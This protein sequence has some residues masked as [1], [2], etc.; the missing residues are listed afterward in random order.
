M[1]IYLCHMMFFRIVEKLAV[2]R[3]TR[4]MEFNYLIST[5]CTLG[6]AIVFSHIVKY[7]MFP[8]INEIIRKKRITLISDRQ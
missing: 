5:I 6:L 4:S 8:Y 1:E 7:K 2:D 3:L